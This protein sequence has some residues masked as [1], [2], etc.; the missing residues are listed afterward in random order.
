[1]KQILGI[2][3]YTKVEPVRDPL[4]AD[5]EQS[6]IAV[7]AETDGLAMAVGSDSG[8]EWIRMEGNFSAEVEQ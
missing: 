6:A 5:S 4:E 2:H 8:K 3:N 7:S 1:M